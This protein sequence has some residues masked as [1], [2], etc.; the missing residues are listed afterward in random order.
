MIVLHYYDDTVYGYTFPFRGLKSI[1]KDGI[2]NWSG[3][4]ADSGYDRLKFI[5]GT[6]EKKTLGYSE[7]SS[8]VKGNFY[9]NGNVYVSFYINGEEVT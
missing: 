8:D 3:G 7:S 6:V 2:F 1:K 4:F 9:A 5:N